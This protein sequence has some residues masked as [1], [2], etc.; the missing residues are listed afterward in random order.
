[1]ATAVVPTITG[2]DSSPRLS[3]APPRWSA[4]GLLLV[5]LGFFVAQLVL[6]PHPFGRNDGD[7]FGHL[8]HGL[9]DV[10]VDGDSKLGGEACRAHHPQRIIRKGRF[11]RPGRGQHGSMEVAHAAERIHQFQGGQL[12]GH[13]VDGTP[14]WSGS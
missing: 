4:L 9:P 7:P 12:Q 11:R 3:T 13:G 5:G 6:V 14:P 1:M 8:R 2:R 10:L